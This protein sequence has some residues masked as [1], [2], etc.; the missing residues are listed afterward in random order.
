LR[1]TAAPIHR[2]DVIAAVCKARST[3]K[4]LVRLVPSSYSIYRAT[5]V[6]APNNN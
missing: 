4:A 5:L 3:I 6:V 2:F 1:A